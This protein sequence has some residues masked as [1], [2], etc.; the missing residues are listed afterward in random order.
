MLHFEQ[1]TWAKGFSRLA[2][3]DEAGRGPLAGPVVAAAIYIEPDFLRAEAHGLLAGLT[4]S[5]QLSDSRRRHF[6]EVF[7]SSP[8]CTFA[9]A[10][11]DPPEID[12]INILQA[13]HQAMRNALLDLKPPP[14]HALVDGRAPSALPCAFTA[15][16]HGDARSLLIAAASIV[17]KVARDDIMLELDREY[18][19]YGFARH[20]GYGTKAHLA[21]L[22]RH[23]PCPW[24]RRSF[25]PVRQWRGIPRQLTMRVPPAAPE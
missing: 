10:R 2:G 9:V 14:D 3:V 12:R 18:P 25:R 13:T 23:G 1:Q 16:I 6:M 24:H 7:R 22:R 20:K 11:V 17:A 8:T 21:A 4:D 15:I 19:Q 5:K